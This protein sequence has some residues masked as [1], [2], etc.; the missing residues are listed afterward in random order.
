MKTI[1]GNWIMEKDEI[2]NED[3]KVEGNILGKNGE[4]FNL[5]VKG[6]LDCWNLNC[7]NL[8]C[9]DLKCYN[10]DC[11][12]LNC[13]N[14]DCCDLDCYDLDCWDLNFFAV[15]FAYDNIKCKSI[16][17]RRENSRYFV[18]DGKIIIN[19]KEERS[20]F[21]ILFKNYEKTKN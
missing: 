5:Q 6:N 16:K 17:G 18:L 4:I 7:C 12:N 8:N 1:K 10:L 9:W 19:G 20:L 15:C 21:G 13:C 2:I 14:L 3:L 11:R